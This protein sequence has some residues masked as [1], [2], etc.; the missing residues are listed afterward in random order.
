MVSSKPKTR[1][2]LIRR[3]D[4]LSPT[5]F[6]NLTFDLLSLTGMT[7]V[8]WRTPGADGGRD[9]EGTTSEIDLSGATTI[10][11]WYVECKRYATSVDWPTIYAKLAYADSHRVDC[12]LLCTTSRFS[13]AAITHVEGWNSGRRHP[14]IRLWPKHE[15]ELQLLQHPDLQL[16]YRL[17]KATSVPGRSIVTLALALSKAVSSHYSRL[18]FEGGKPDLMIIAAQA[19]ADLLSKRMSDME[20]GGTIE[21]VFS[22]SLIKRPLSES[23]TSKADF[24]PVDELGLRA[25]VAYLAALT[26]AQSEISAAGSD[27]CKII[28]SSPIARVVDRYRP[29]FT[30]IATWADFEFVVSTNE[31]HIR[32]R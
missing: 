18:Q 7:N 4:A 20:R 19:F 9:I 2:T 1:V 31:I 24:L 13:P 27:G 16:K 29:V 26:R 10:R 12:L 25:F 23:C 30:A 14:A 22:S 11:K 8:S 17:T 15:L 3:L 6:E 5:E 32:Q 21:V 28:S